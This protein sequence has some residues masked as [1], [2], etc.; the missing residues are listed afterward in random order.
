M[1]VS[2]VKGKEVAVYKVDGSKVSGT[3]VRIALPGQPG[4]MRARAR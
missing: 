3:G 4:S 1:Y 2:N